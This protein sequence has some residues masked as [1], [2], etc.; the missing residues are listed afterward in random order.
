[1][2][3]VIQIK[4]EKCPENR[5]RLYT[6]L[7]QV[8]PLGQWAEKSGLR[9][10]DQLSKQNRSEKKKKFTGGK[11]RPTDPRI[12]TPLLSHP[13]EEK[14][15]LV[16]GRAGILFFG[17]ASLGKGVGKGSQRRGGG[18]GTGGE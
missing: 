3:I 10:I 6:N 18:G 8:G 9:P 2:Q 7:G 15:D 11:G 1:M 16:R 12:L 5:P 4:K 14:R 17:N 13:T